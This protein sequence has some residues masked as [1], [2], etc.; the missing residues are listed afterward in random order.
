MLNP[1]FKRNLWLQFSLHRLVATPI[2]LALV[3]LA[4]QI[5]GMVGELP[6][7][8]RILFI[9]IVW[10]WG[11]RNATSSIADELRDKTWDQ[12]RMSALQPWAMTWGKLF[13]ATS[14]NWY[15][16]IICLLVILVTEFLTTVSL[17]ERT[18]M[19][20]MIAMGILMH[21]AAMA[22]SVHIGIDKTI[23]Q[24]G[25]ISWCIVAMGL[26]ARSWL[27]QLSSNTI[28]W[29]HM[30]YDR[31]SFLLA[32]SLGFAVIAVFAAWRTMSNALQVR[33]IPWAWPLFAC[34]F[35]LYCAG[36]YINAAMSH[37]LRIGLMVAMTMTYAALFSESHAISIWQRIVVRI[38]TRNWRGVVEQ[39]PISITT[40]VLTFSFAVASFFVLPSF[41]QNNIQGIGQGLLDRVPGGRYLPIMMAFMLLR[42]VLVFLFFAFSFNPKRVVTTTLLYLVIINGLLPFLAKAMNLDTLAYFF[43]PFYSLHAGSI[44][45]MIAQVAIAGALVVWQWSIQLKTNT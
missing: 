30:P 22:A 3:F 27:A 20:S 10:L 41:Q 19:L 9:G 23:I 24:R 43:V 35:S 12:Q 36:F 8:G 42:D 15:G 7:A 25:G 21:A 17:S 45:I 28:V 37:F 26:F 29:W 11:T 16:G 18:P 14:F 1:E 33:T 40:V 32:S 44:I 38:Q 2:L 39:L 6:K 5:S 13:G 34:L 4:I 31:H